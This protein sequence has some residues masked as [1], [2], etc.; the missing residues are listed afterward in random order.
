MISMSAG[1]PNIDTVIHE[2]TVRWPA[3][4][5]EAVH[6]LVQRLGLFVQKEAMR[7]APISPTQ[8]QYDAARRGPGRTAN[9]GRGAGK[10][11]A[12]KHPGGLSIRSIKTELSGD[13]SE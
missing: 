8:A 2:I 1:V 13:R 12:R 5:A 4:A 3:R 10:G 7:R 11:Y 6:G 9:A